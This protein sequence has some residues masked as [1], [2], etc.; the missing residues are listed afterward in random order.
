MALLAA[1][2]GALVWLT[3]GGLLRARRRR[4]LVGR[5][6]FAAAPA[7]QP[8]RVLC[9]GDSLT[10]SSYPAHLA[11]ELERRGCAAEVLGLGFA[12]DSSVELLESLGSVDLA[13]LA[14]DVTVLL[15]GTNDSRIDRNHVPTPRF[16]AA[17]ERLCERLLGTVSAAGRPYLA[18]CT[19]PPVVPVPL[20]F[21]ADS[22]RRVR[23]ELNPAI[24]ALGRRLR[25]P[26]VELEPRL[27]PEWL[28]PGDVH[29]TEAGYER[30]AR[31]VAETL[32]PWLVLIAPAVLDSSPAADLR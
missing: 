16:E 14:P 1:A 5:A 17:L 30:I 26:V 18:L 8:L 21:S 31:T 25:L 9:L 13:S 29:P 7:P 20:H 2:A 28:R 4:R 32:A 19:L 11:A 27:G 10:D 22:L 6:R 15:V 12:G 3:L 23:D 24:R